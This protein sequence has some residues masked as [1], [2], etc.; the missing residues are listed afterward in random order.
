M[1][2]NASLAAYPTETKRTWPSQQRLRLQDGQTRS[3]FEAI[4][5]EYEVTFQLGD[6]WQ[7]SNPTFLEICVNNLPQG[8]IE[9][10]SKN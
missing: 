6:F 10:N 5:Q 2:T 9:R 1:K 8:A 4:E 3:I 7:A